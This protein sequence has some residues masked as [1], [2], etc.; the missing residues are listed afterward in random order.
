MDAGEAP[1]GCVLARGDGSIVVSGHNEQNRTQNKTAH[2]EIVAFARAAGKNAARRARPDH[3]QH[4][5]ALRDVHRR[6]N[7]GGGRYDRLRAATPRPIPARAASPV[8]PAR[9]RR[10]RASSA[11]PRARQSGTLRG[12]VKKDLPRS[13]GK[14]GE[15]LL[16]LT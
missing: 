14:F 3:G 5:R 11:D 1:I 4:A 13:S 7:G 9:N 12:M 15:Q 16:K 6:R 2:A 8:P 10:C